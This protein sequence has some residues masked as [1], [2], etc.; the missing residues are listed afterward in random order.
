M[1]LKIESILRQQLSALW[2]LLR[3]ERDGHAALR[4]DAERYRWLRAKAGQ[5][6]DWDGLQ[7]VEHDGLPPCELLD[8]TVDAAMLATA[9]V[10]AA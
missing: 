6:I 3:A 1:D 7:S 5:A 10:G 2:E 9:A 8:T 4:K